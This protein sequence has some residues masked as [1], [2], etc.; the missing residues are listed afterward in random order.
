M[1]ELVSHSPSVKRRRRY[2]REFKQQLVEASRDP[3]RSVA[4]V[5]LEHGVNANQLHLWRKQFNESGSN[6]F[7][8]LPSS[9]VPG[10]AI[11]N[12]TVRIELPGGMIVHWP[13]DRM[14]ES[15]A[16]LKALLP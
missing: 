3:G 2:S 1:H 16:W 9:T 8:R 10:G 15:V 11:T 4:S 5:A 14:N 7:V 6:G 12:E 13:M